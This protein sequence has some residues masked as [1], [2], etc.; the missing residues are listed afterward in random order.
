M[1]VAIAPPPKRPASAVAA[2]V[3]GRELPCG[4]VVVGADACGLGLARSLG[5]GKM[6]VVI[7]DTDPRRP[8]MHSRFARP[9]V[10]RYMSGPGLVED[11][12]AIAASFLCRPALFLTSDAQAATVSE[13]RVAL[14]EA[15]RI[16]LPVH[17]C[18]MDLLNKTA[19]QRYAEEHGFP[20]PAS[21]IIRSDSDLSHL[22][23]IRFPAVVKPGTKDAFFSDLAP[24]A[25][26]VPNR[27][28]AEALCRSIIPRAP[29]LIVQ[30]WIDGDE[31]DIYFCLQYRAADRST[32]ASFTGR[33]IRTWP[34]QTGSTASC[35]PAPEAEPE[36]E[37]LTTAF[38]DKVGF[39]GLGSMEY[40]R[41]RSSR[42]F[43]MIEPTVGRADW[44]EEVATLNGVNI[45]LAAYCHDMELPPPAPGVPEQMRVWRD[46]ACFWRAVAETRSFTRSPP[47]T[48]TVSS[49]WRSDDRMPFLYGCLDW[50]GKLWR[51]GPGRH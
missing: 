7:A 30:E 33:K 47:G 11:L 5:V 2:T 35:L 49:L 29:D 32:V 21:A 4:A 24:R 16:T 1:N 43:V 23:D 45:P 26:R 13:H 38:F 27:A 8:G 15:Y 34:P 46:P 18:L 39:I 28:E 40:K 51:Q 19:F 50:A 42:R 9:A 31:A 6:P 20:V 22:A 12:L 48:V 41:D 10:V 37:A 36:L 17:R 3:S 44:Q 14:Q 25:E